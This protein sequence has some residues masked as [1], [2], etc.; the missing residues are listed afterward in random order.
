MK[1]K[2]YMWI[3]VRTLILLLIP[4][5]GNHFIEGWNWSLFDFVWAFVMIAGVQFLYAFISRKAKNSTYKLASGVALGTAFVL[6]WVN[7]AVSII[8]D[9]PANFLYLGL[10]IILAGG[11]IIARFKPQAMSRV[12]YVTAFCVLL[13]PVIALYSF[14]SVFHTDLLHVFGANIFFAGLF[15]L[16]GMLFQKSAL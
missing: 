1:T 7:A 13:V 4:L 9:G 10:L 16:S 15:A 14:H 12:L 2:T 3:I 5:Y 11:A 8:G 6:V